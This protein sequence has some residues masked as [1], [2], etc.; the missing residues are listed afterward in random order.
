MRPGW[1]IVTAGALLLLSFGAAADERKRFMEEVIVTA[2]YVEKS[3]QDTAIALSALDN[4]FMEELGIADIEDF[5]IF[6]PSL[7]RDVLDLTIRGVG[8]N[9]RTL[10]GD[11]GVPIYYNGVYLEE[12]INGGSEN[13]YYDLNRIE[14]LRGP[15]GTLY[16]RNAIGGV[17]N[18]ISNP[19]TRDFFAEVKTRGGSYDQAD[20]HGILSGPLIRDV[21]HYRLVGV[22]INQGPD[23]PSRSAP[24]Q[25]SVSDTGG[26][27]D[28]TISLSLAYTPTDN[29][30]IDFRAL[31]RYYR[32]V[33]RAPVYLGEGLG[34]R[35]SRSS[36]VCFPEGTDCFNEPAGDFIFR[37]PLNP[38]ALQNLP[39]N[40]DGY[41]D[42]LENWTYPDFKP[43]FGYRYNS[44]IGDVQWHFD[45]GRYTLRTL[46]GMYDVTWGKWKRH[47]YSGLGGRNSC[48][49]PE[50]TT[51]PDGEQLSAYSAANRYPLDQLS[52]EVQLISNLDGRLN[53]VA[54]MFYLDLERRLRIDQA[55][56]A[57]L[58]LYTEEPSW[59]LV[60]P[61]DF[62]APPLGPGRHNLGGADSFTNYFGGTATGS[63]FW[64][65]STLNTR[66]LATYLQATYE[67][68]DRWQL[69]AGLRWSRDEKVGREWRWSYLEINAEFFGFDSLADFNRQITT[70]PSTGAYNGDPFRLAGFPVERIDSLR[71][72]DAWEK[73]TWRLALSWQPNDKTLVYGSATTGYRAGG[74]NLG[75]HQE[76]PYDSEENLAYEIGLKT[77]LLDGRLRLNLSSYLY[78]YKNHQV[79]ANAVLPTRVIGC[80]FGCFEDGDGEALF[81]SAVQNVPRARNIGTELEL[82]WIATSSLALGL[83]H[84]Y[85]ETEITSDFFVSRE[86]NPWSAFTSSDQVNLR[87]GELNRSPRNKYTLWANYRIPM[88][89]NGTINLFGS[90]AHTDQ[91]Y[92]DVLPDRINEAPSYQRWDLRATWDSAAGRYRVS[93][94]VKNITNELGIVEIR[95]SE[96]FGRIGDTTKPRVWGLEF[97]IRFGAWNQST[98][99]DQIDGPNPN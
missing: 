76:F 82:T 72:E 29:F 12:A 11:V 32:V 80:N 67:F 9:Y 89:D 23:R 13:G 34:D 22:S 7:T 35:T 42:D 65:D 73:V 92:F 50:C 38:N 44:Y 87:G 75:I 46:L 10:G 8:R 1:K 66:A 49:P 93:A 19:P 95:P 5:M 39:V 14:V 64:F 16:G 98:G 28:N 68:N 84:S 47:Y 54:G 18:F 24:G 33:P 70:D 79:F 6:I 99:M 21:L 52:A 86:L 30:S 56:S 31:E 58:G 88:G 59:G 78:R 51:G 2:E 74:F 17:V 48:V 43:D 36:A 20:F 40:G 85:M 60:N 90:F 15:Q 57:Q 63:W 77:D 83:V 69:T 81:G 41:G 94:F 91:Q 3:A 45:H 61:G 71:I 26:V 97:R 25:A 55:D 62:F 27:E 4:E 96:N 37:P 53:F